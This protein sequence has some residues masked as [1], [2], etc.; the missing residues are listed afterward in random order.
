[1]ALPILELELQ[2]EQVD[3]SLA[4]IDDV[5]TWGIGGAE[6][7]NAQANFLIAAKVDKNGVPTFLVVNT[8]DP[9]NQLEW[10][11]PTA[12]DG[13][14][15]FW[16]LRIPLFSA[17]ASY[18]IEVKNAQGVVTTPASI[19]YNTVTGKV[20]KAKVPVTPAAFNPLQ[21]DI[22]TDLSTIIDYGSIVTHLHRDLIDCY[23]R[24]QY[25]DLLEDAI[26]EFGTDNFSTAISFEKADRVD[27]LLNGANALNWENK[28]EEMEEVVVGLTQF[29]K[30]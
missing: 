29:A 30:V 23:L 1:M 2:S 11:I 10:V 3:C 9:L 24:A 14:Y 5:S 17:I 13:S 16:L 20:Y 21:W 19:V 7:R 12:V 6:A 15:Y 4:Y 28:S 22:I 27:T 18:V 26:D 25:R 8:S